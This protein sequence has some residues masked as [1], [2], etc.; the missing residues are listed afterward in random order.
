M[1]TNSIYRICGVGIEPDEL[2]DFFAALLQEA[3]DGVTIAV[4]VQVDAC[5]GRI[6]AVL[7]DNPDCLPTG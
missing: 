5:V 6:D 2:R 1:R 3:S 7:R 4:T